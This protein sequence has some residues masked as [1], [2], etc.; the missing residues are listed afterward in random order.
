MS[1]QRRGGTMMYRLAGVAG[2]L[3][4]LLAGA[5]LGD[6]VAAQ[7]RQVMDKWQQVVVTVRLVIQ[8][9]MAFGGT[10]AEVSENKSEATGVVID[11]SGLTVVSLS[12]T[13]PSELFKRFMGRYE[14]E[15]D[16]FK[17]D[18]KV[19]DLKL[20]LA[21]G[22][23]VPAKVVLRD[24]DLDLAF[25]RPQEKPAEPLAAV[26]LAQAAPVEVMDQVVVLSRLGAVGDWGIAVGVDRIGAVLHKPRTMYVPWS[27]GLMGG[28]GAPVFSLEGR[29]IGVV[30][31][32]ASPGA[33]G[34]TI[35][36]GLDDLGILP[37]L[38]PAADI[39]EVAK[40]A[41]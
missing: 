2:L 36:T 31:M 37:V 27:S 9:K 8:T 3:G 14:S 5:A 32:R 35:M 16:A 23:E 12:E 18:S 24:K 25:L 1:G 39:L 33:G 34:F 26:D 10:D 11:P 6:D 19:T 7:A 38:L 17:M 40:Q 20:R 22:K 28:L 15:P 29:I 4:V 30:V 21:D 41:Q 13:D